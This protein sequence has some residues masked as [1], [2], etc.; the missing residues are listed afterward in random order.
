M[1]IMLDSRMGSHLQRFARTAAHLAEREGHLFRHQWCATCGAARIIHGE[2]M[3]SISPSWYDIFHYF[4]GRCFPNNWW[5]LIQEISPDAPW[6]WNMS[7]HLD[8][9]WVFFHKIWWKY[10][11]QAERRSDSIFSVAGRIANFQRTHIFCYH[12]VMFIRWM[13]AVQ[14]WGV[15]VRDFTFQAKNGS[16]NHVALTCS[17]ATRYPLKKGKLRKDWDANPLTGH[18][19]CTS[20]R[21]VT[22]KPYETIRLY[23]HS[24]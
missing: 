20:R 18:N 2:V 14:W 19:P 8:H 16:G 15:P 22:M 6:C 1:C 4:H 5:N 24:C 3:E 11:E 13:W 10:G 17:D 9:P 21:I 23:D 12:P 7:L